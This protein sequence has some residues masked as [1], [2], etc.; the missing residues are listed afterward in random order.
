MVIVTISRLVGS[1]GDVIAAIV[2]KQMGL[3]LVGRQQVH[4]LA[5][6]CDREYDDACLVYETELGPTFWER[7]FFDRP[8]YTSLFQA[9][10]FEEA[11]RGNVVLIGRGAQ[12]VLRD[13]PGVLKVRTV[14]PM[15]VRIKRIMERYDISS[16]EAEE[17]IRKYDHERDNLARSIFRQDEND[18]ALYDL[19]VNTEHFSSADAAQ[20]VIT[21]AEKME[22]VPDPEEIQ[23]K[24][25]S[26]A[27]AKRVEALIRKKL[28]SAIARNVEVVANSYGVLTITG[29]IRSLKEK[30]SAGELAA[31]HAG[32]TK[33][34]NDLKVTEFSFGV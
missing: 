13:I 29:R 3:Q 7:I 16:E 33:V 5:Q 19:V 14:A 11:S 21:A 25:R 24:L 8:A 1:F 34:N 18:P 32:V 28:T 2:A 22:K 30:G 10:N 9:L 6:S 17:F 23:E 15:S 27:L 20:I 31:A 26:M 4:E 12:I